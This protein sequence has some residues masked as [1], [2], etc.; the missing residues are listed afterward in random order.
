MKVRFLFREAICLLFGHKNYKNKYN[1]HYCERC[2]H[3]FKDHTMYKEIEKETRQFVSLIVEDVEPEDVDNVINAIQQDMLSGA[4]IALLQVMK[5][6]KNGAN[7][8]EISEECKEAI[9]EIEDHLF[10][11]KG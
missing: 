8:W 1:W 11:D 6:I 7:Q 9:Q 10:Y 2:Y 4:R 3:I 5:L